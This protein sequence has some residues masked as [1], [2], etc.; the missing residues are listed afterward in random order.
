MVGGKTR[1]RVTIISN[2]DFKIPLLR[3]RYK[4]MGI[5]TANKIAVVNEASFNVKNRV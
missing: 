3:E 4:A 1:G 5:L 2:I